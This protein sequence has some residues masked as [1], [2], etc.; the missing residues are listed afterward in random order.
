M[1]KRIVYED[2]LTHPGE[3]KVEK[4]KLIDF[5][6]RLGNPVKMKEHKSGFPAVTIDCCNI[7][8]ITDCL[9]VEEWWVMSQLYQAV[10][11]G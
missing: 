7:H 6:Y 4:Y 11:R 8:L 3:E 9:S 10:P 2:L 1:F 5:L